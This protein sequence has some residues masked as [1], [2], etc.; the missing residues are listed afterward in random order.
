MTETVLTEQARERR[1]IETA[2]KRAGDV[3]NYIDDPQKVLDKLVMLV[4]QMLKAER[5]SIML[6]DEDNNELR[7]R[8]SYGIPPEIVEA[9]RGSPVD[10]IAGWVLSNG[11]PLLIEN[12]G[13]HPFSRGVLR[14]CYT[15]AS[16]L[17]VPLAARY[18]PLG[19]LNVNNKADGTIFTKADELLLT[20]V[21]SFVVI[22]LEKA[23]TRQIVLQKERLDAE[24]GVAREIQA[25]LL[26]TD[27]PQDDRIQI[28]TR[29]VPARQ[30]AGDFYDLLELDGKL[31]ILVGDVCGKGVPA[32][33]YMA[34]VLSCFRTVANLLGNC[35]DLFSMVNNQLEPEWTASS[36]VTASLV[37]FNEDRGAVSVSSAGHLPPYLMRASTGALTVLDRTEGLPL[38]V[39]KDTV[40]SPHVE[41]LKVG[42][43][44][45]IL[46]DGIAEALS[47]KGE[48]FGEARI[49]NA[50][51][52]QPGSAE[53]IADSLLAAVSAFA[54]PRNQTDDQT[55]IVAVRNAPPEDYTKPRPSNPT[56]PS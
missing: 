46:T 54:G 23:R 25:S 22:T 29:F 15:T 52:S 3:V 56:R 2:L 4:V 47:P 43:A 20:I 24:I 8:A 16:L 6:F 17:S 11:K 53:H 1:L 55:I 50:L 40:F 27:M 51:R 45:V 12:L 35:E 34:R 38:G 5:C 32:A 9:Y 42:D 44:V 30:V 31:A 18:R 13:A 19:V 48:L 21:A 33:F 7:I 28:A 39:Q 36:F 14:D 41:S 49:Q 10:P 37:V 26:R